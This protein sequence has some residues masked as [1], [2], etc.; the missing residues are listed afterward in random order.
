MALQFLIHLPKQR[1]SANSRMGRYYFSQKHGLHVY[2]G[3]ALTRAEFDKVSEKVLS[4]TS[5]ASRPL[6]KIIGEEDGSEI[7]LADV[8]ALIDELDKLRDE[9][10]TLRATLNAAV[11]EPAVEPVVEPAVESAEAEP[12]KSKKKK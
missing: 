1:R 3:K 11:V 5:L 10:A 12:T 2:E 7:P 6:V 4:D 8:K 9:N